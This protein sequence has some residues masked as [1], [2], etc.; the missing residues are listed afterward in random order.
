MSDR[1]RWIDCYKGLAIML[2]VL[3]HLRIGEG[4]Y[5]FL[6]SFHMYA[7]FFI[8]GITRKPS[9]QPFF[10][11]LTE[12]LRR[13]YVPYVAYAALWV[14]T[15]LAMGLYQGTADLP[16]VAQ[17]GENALNILLGGG[18]ISGAAQVGPAWFL[19]ALMVVRLAYD[20]LD[21][22]CRQKQA[23]LAA[24]A[25][26]FFLLAYVLEGYAAVPLRMT[27]ALTAFGFYWAGDICKALPDALARVFD[28]GWRRLGWMAM[29]AAAFLTVAWMANLS[30]KALILG[31]NI[32]PRPWF[33]P[34]V[35]GFAGCLGLMAV[36]LLLERVP[37]AGMLAGF[38]GGCSMVIMGLHSQLRL[39]LYLVLP[40]SGWV[41]EAAVFAL[42]LGLSVPVALVMGR[43]LP[44]LA[45]KKKVY[46]SKY[47]NN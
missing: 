17:L 43:Y 6:F 25:A 37:V 11:L 34:L 18:V 24:V 4:L 31:G 16:T 44:I 39:G 13:L 10:R 47:S 2:V 28:R 9:R 19:C 42:S 3:G 12:N 22:L 41:L 20:G 40:L 27:A 46:G 7:F 30:D 14:A 23:V 36:S 26:A 45:G 35:A 15:E 1:K 29:A 33:V 38:F 8:G 5:R 21:R 32:L